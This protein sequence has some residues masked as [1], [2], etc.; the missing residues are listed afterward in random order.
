[1]GNLVLIRGRL[2]EIYMFLVGECKRVLR[3]FFVEFLSPLTVINYVDGPGQWG[4][5]I[6]VHQRTVRYPLVRY[7]ALFLYTFSVSHCGNLH[8]FKKHF[9]HVA[10]FSF[11]L[12]FRVILFSCCTFFILQ[13]CHVPFFSCCIISMFH[14]F[15]YQSFHVALLMLHSFHICTNSYC[16]FTR[17]NVF[18]LLSSPV[19]DVAVCSCCTLFM[20]HCFNFRGVV[21]TTTNI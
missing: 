13:S 4:Q 12:F 11:C 10:F 17:C 5:C 19:A 9:F 8:F 3:P 15:V 14:F 1:M 2:R 7:S 18:F 16:T 21:M 6:T 20:L